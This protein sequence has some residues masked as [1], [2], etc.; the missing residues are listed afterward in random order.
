MNPMVFPSCLTIVVMPDTTPKYFSEKL[1]KTAVYA[2]VS[3]RETPIPKGMMAE[4][5]LSGVGV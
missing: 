1:P 5:I 4:R 2:G 3:I